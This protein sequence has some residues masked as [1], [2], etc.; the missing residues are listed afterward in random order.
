M[1]AKLEYL[2]LEG[3]QV[4]FVHSKVAACCKVSRVNLTW[5]L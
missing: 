3:N 5:W 2:D 1:T 4:N